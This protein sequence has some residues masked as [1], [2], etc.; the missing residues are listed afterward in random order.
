MKSESNSKMSSK[1]LNRKI[2][3]PV[4]FSIIVILLIALSAVSTFVLLPRYYDLKRMEFNTKVEEYNNKITTINKVI[5]LAKQRSIPDIPNRFSELS[6][7][8][9]ELWEYIQHGGNPFGIQTEIS[10]METQLEDY[11]FQFNQTCQG[12]YDKESAEYN[13][14]ADAYNDMLKIT[15]VAYI[16]DLPEGITKKEPRDI[17]INDQYSDSMFLKEINT[18]IEEKDA[19]ILDYLLVEQITNPNEEWLIERMQKVDSIKDVAAVTSDNDPNGL[20][21]KEGGYTSCIYFTIKQIDDKSIQGDNVIAKGTD[22]GGAIENYLSAEDAMNRCNYLSQFDDSVLVSGSY[23]IIGTMVVRT[24][25]KLSQEE[26]IALTNEITE[27]LTK[28]EQ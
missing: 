2:K 11:T 6:R 13:I 17:E 25:Y 4:I 14:I 23:T 18:L 5:D 9:M 15:T 1:K 8:E 19:L 12:F 28:V 26:Q 7:N 16:M 10:Q 21:G 3:A 27:V 20:L 24:S 22:A